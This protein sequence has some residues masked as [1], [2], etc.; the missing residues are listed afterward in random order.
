MSRGMVDHPWLLDNCNGGGFSPNGYREEEASD[1][2]E[3]SEIRTQRVKDSVTPFSIMLILCAV[4]PPFKP[5]YDNP[6]FFGHKYSCGKK[7]ATV[8][9][10]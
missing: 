10:A 3:L 1:E 6:T 4:S 2:I 7:D 9:H 8:G 5:V